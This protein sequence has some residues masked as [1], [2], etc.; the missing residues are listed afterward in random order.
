[1]PSN[2][3]GLMSLY[4]DAPIHDTIRTMRR[5]SGLIVAA[6]LILPAFAETKVLKNF[7]LIDGTGKPAAPAMSM[8]LVDGRIR[9]IGPAGKIKAPENAEVIDLSGKF[10]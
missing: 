7:T 3:S 1:M 6:L 10:V 4:P 8:I 5:N 2:G 9:S